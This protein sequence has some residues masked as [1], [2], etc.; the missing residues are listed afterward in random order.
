MLF[1]HAFLPAGEMEKKKKKAKWGGDKS[2]R[3]HSHRASY[4]AFLKHGCFQNYTVSINYSA[5]CNF[6]AAWLCW[7]Q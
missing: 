2:E 5:K 6:R 4:K 1:K 7:D 3:K